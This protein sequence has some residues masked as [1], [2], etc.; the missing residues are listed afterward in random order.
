MNSSPTRTSTGA[1]A[2]AGGSIAIWSLA[3]VRR[4]YSWILAISFRVIS[5]LP[6]GNL[7]LSRLDHLF[8]PA[9]WKRPGISE[10]QTETLSVRCHLTRGHGHSSTDGSF[11]RFSNARGGAPTANWCHNPGVEPM[12]AH[13]TAMGVCQTI[14]GHSCSSMWQFFAVPFKPLKSNHWPQHLVVI[15]FNWHN[16]S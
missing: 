6:A 10:F 3:K 8:Q 15:W 13:V 2:F 12:C 4:R 16:L 5:W 14:N 7:R 9:R 11:Y 1:V